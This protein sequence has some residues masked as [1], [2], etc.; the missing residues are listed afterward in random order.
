LTIAWNLFGLAMLAIAIGTVATSNPGWLH[1]KWP[2]EPFSAIATWLVIWIPA[3][4]APIGI[5]LHIVSICQSFSR[6][7][8]QSVQSRRPSSRRYNLKHAMMI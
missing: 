1:L 3:R 5:Y 2:D 4:L 8:D 7:T 6:Q